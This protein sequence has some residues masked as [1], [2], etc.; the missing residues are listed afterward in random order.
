M[1]RK[2]N[3]IKILFYF[4][5]FVSIGCGKYIISLVW[6]QGWSLVF[7]RY[8]KFFER[9]FDWLIYNF[10]GN[11]RIYWY[12]LKRIYCN[13]PLCFEFL[14]HSPFKNFLCFKCHRLK[15]VVQK[16]KI[17]K[18]VTHTLKFAKR[19]KTKSCA[20]QVTLRSRKILRNIQWV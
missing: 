2:K 18:K 19:W 3:S 11:W 20:K 7:L 16:K 10:K 17:S 6:N 12:Q 15:K 8:F 13:F 4:E 14:I 1:S 9:Y 5:K